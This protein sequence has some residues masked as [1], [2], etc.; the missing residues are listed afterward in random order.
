MASGQE[1]QTKVA[2]FVVAASV[3]A[4]RAAATEKT[5]AEK[6]AA[7]EALIPGVVAEMV[8]NDRISASQADKL[9]EMLRDPAATLK[10]LAKT[11]SHR[12]AAEVAEDQLSIGRGVGGAGTEKTG[13]AG[14]GVDT[15][16][17]THYNGR[18]RSDEQFLQA[19]GIPVNA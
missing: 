8:A 18:R 6:A 11:A 9:A 12:N 5:A 13:G 3:I 16:V 15:Y 7:C 1:F 17:G 2:D 14:Q 4:E 10:I 19:F